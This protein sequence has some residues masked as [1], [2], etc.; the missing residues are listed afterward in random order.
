MR[1]GAFRLY[2]HKHDKYPVLIY[3]SRWDSPESARVYLD[4]YK[5]VLKGKWRMLQILSDTGSMVSGTGDS[6]KFQV[7]LVGSSV[8]SVEGLR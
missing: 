8:E 2:E 3:T 7:R 5:R 4:L 6:G 1:G